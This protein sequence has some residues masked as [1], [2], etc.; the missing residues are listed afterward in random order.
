M[1]A[2][3]IWHLASGIWHLA[4]GIWQILKYQPFN[5]PVLTS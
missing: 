5:K 3:G 4:S 2:S 1:L